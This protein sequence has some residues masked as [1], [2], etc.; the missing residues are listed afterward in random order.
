ML[1]WLCLRSLTPIGYTDKQPP[2]S[3]NITDCTNSLIQLP[4]LHSLVFQ[5]PFLTSTQPDSLL[6]I[7]PS[8]ARSALPV[9]TLVLSCTSSTLSLSGLHPPL[10][11]IIHVCSTSRCASLSLLYPRLFSPPWPLAYVLPQ[12]T[13]DAIHANTSSLPSTPSTAG[14]K[15]FT[16]LSKAWTTSPIS[17]TRS[18]S[19]T[20]TT[21]PV[22]QTRKAYTSTPRSARSLPASRGLRS[23]GA[24]LYVSLLAS[25]PLLPY[26]N[27]SII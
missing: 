20:F 6:F 13:K 10:T 5:N 8:L 4:S 23:A 22:T 21:S 26:P 17:W 12:P 25:S 27:S 24:T 7:L 11:F 14:E 16:P 1:H 15:R 3:I 9:S 18:P 2:A 19:A